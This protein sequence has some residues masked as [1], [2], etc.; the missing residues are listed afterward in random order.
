MHIM[1]CTLLVHTK[2]KLH[3]STQNVKICLLTVQTFKT[4]Y[5]RTI[6]VRDTFPVKKNNKKKLPRNFTT[7]K[8][9]LLGKRIGGYLFSLRSFSATSLPLLLPTPEV[10]APSSP[11]SRFHLPLWVFVRRCSCRRWRRRC[12]LSVLRC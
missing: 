11:L 5:P 3:I 12:P 7:K 6:E 10:C 8:S 2:V 9:W 1:T 4:N